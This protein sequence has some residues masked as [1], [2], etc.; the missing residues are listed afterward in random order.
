VPIYVSGFGPQAAE[1]AGRIGDGYVLV[2]PE[3]ELVKAFRESGGGDKPVQAGVKVSWDKDTDT[4]LKVAHRM[5]GNDALPG[6]S[7]QTL[8]R[9]MDFAALMSLVTPKQVA[10]SIACGPDPDKHAARVREY[11]DADI[12]EVYVQQIGPDMDGFFTTWEKSVLP[13]LR[14]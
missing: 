13:D 12:D 4:A 14:S 11:V 2:T 9:P 10:E 5:W 1:L 6:Q 8:P 7:A 3:A